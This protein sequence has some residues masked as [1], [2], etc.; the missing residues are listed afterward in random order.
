MDFYFDKFINVLPKP[1]MPFP[2]EGLRLGLEQEDPVCLHSIYRLLV[3]FV[4]ACLPNYLLPAFSK[5]VKWINEEVKPSRFLLPPVYRNEVLPSV[6]SPVLCVYIRKDDGKDMPYC[7]GELRFMSNLYVYAV[8]Y[9][10]ERDANFSEMPKVLDSFVK[11]CYPGIEFTIQN[12]C[13]DELKMVVNHVLIGEGMDVVCKP[14]DQ[15][16]ASREKNGGRNE[17]GR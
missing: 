2:K 3:K 12:Y 17:M 11:T 10:S 5:T 15:E 6:D 9:C 4:I 7:V 14:L 13:D 8:P 16:S 1:G